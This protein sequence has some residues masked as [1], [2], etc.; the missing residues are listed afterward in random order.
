MS[1]FTSTCESVFLYWFYRSGTFPC[2]WRIPQQEGTALL[3]VH[4]GSGRQEG[5]SGRRAAELQL[6]CCLVKRLL[7]VLVKELCRAAEVFSQEGRIPPAGDGKVFI[8]FFLTEIIASS[9]GEC[10]LALC[11]KEQLWFNSC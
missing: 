9:P 11:R 7:L 6:S 3:L 5:G 2:P 4:G 1:Y 8:F 10:G